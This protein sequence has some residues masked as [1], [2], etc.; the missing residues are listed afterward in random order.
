MKTCEDSGK[1]L[2]IIGSLMCMA[3]VLLLFGSNQSAGVWLLGI[4]FAIAVVG[5]LMG[6]N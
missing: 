5:R 3:G 1:I 4:G 6:S 2:V